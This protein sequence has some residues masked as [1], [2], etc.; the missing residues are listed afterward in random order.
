M[1]RCCLCFFFKK[2]FVSHKHEE[3][4]N[5][6]SKR[7]HGVK[8]Q[9]SSLSSEVNFRTE[10]FT[11]TVYYTARVYTDDIQIRCEEKWECKQIVNFGIWLPG[12]LY[13]SSQS[14]WHQTHNGAG[15]RRLVSCPGH[16][17]THSHTQTHTHTK[18]VCSVRNKLRFCVRWRCASRECLC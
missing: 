9:G 11:S 7:L 2:S 12:A 10:T 17:R 18:S 4:N 13:T 3:E 14:V 1:N 16:G 8:V 6:S 15:R 5:S